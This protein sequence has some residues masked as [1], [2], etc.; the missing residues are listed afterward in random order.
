MENKGAVGVVA[1]SYYS[2]SGYNDGFSIGMINTIWPSPGLS[3]SFGSGA[4][5]NPYGTQVDFVSMGDVVNQGL[6]RM[7]ATWG[8]NQYTHELYHWFGDPAMRIWTEN[9]NP[10]A[11]TASYP[12]TVPSG[13][14]SMSISS[15]SEADAI[16]TLCQ[17][18]L[19]L[20]KETL[21]GGNGT[22][23][24]DPVSG[25][26]PLVL[27]ISKHNC[28]PLI[29]NI[30]IESCTLPVSNFS[31]NIIQATSATNI[32]FSDLTGCSP[33]LWH[34]NFPGGHPSYSTDQNPV[35]RYD[36][37]G[38][39]DVVL[40]TFNA[41]GSNTMC[42]T[43][44]I[45]ICDTTYSNVMSD[46]CNAAGSWDMTSG[47]GNWM[48][49]DPTTPPDDHTGSGNCFITNGNSFYSRD[50]TTYILT[51]PS[52]DLSGITG[53]ELTFW[54]YLE[55]EGENW[56][57]GFIELFDGSNWNSVS[58]NYLDPPYDGALSSSWGNP[59]GGI[60]AWYADRTVWTLV[61]VDL[62]GA[63]YDNISD[64]KVRF[65]FGADDYKQNKTGWAIDDLSI[66]TSSIS[67]TPPN[68]VWTGL[69]GDNNW[70]TTANWS[71]NS[72][73][74]STTNVFIPQYKPGPYY[75]ETFTLTNEEVGNLTIESNAILRVPS[76]ISLTVNGDLSIQE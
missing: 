57:G 53:C 21:S 29:D 24:F 26:S 14:T 67:D 72:V 33:T 16:A 58:D 59:Y 20:S 17:D 62:S 13:A 43:N 9:P 1:A 47:T 42:K 66:Q 74:T 68:C 35:I 64:F 61:S 3:A 4:S 45:T 7:A 31:A 27:T 55:Q 73:P 70:H 22:L 11:I 41:L 19:L 76:G 52:V 28:K 65:K 56:D 23:L 25:P 60:S 63:G 50:P 39:F 12:T 32:S 48:N 6:I 36:Y 15:C 71:C 34:W 75:P 8:N 2:Y 69:G 38:T 37:A 49:V 30:S 18:G 5:P 44:F 51:S 54:M 10:N 46:N 40:T